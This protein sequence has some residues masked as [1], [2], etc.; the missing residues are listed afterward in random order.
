MTELPASGS[1]I[2][3]HSLALIGSTLYW[4]QGGNPITASLN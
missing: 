2:D 1:D 4:A 3:P